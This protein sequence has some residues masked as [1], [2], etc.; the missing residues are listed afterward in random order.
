MRVLIVYA[1]TEGQTRKI[2]RHCAAQLLNA[3]HSVEV[4]EAAAAEP[5][6]TEGVDAVILAGSLHISRFQTELAAFAKAA[7]TTLNAMPTLF[8]SVSL[9]AAGDDPD[10][11]T[12][13]DKAVEGFKNDTGLATPRVVH[14]AGA[15]RFTEYDF[16]R[17]W[18]MRWIASRKGVEVDPHADLEMTDW[19]ALD[20]ALQDWATR[21][22]G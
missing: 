4:I 19:P 2:A 8:L 6:D 1:T 7:A 17:S 13:L 11:W 5:E 21:P 3:G 10:D 9:A 14:V 12:G 18:A 15:F 20:T 16:F 22:A